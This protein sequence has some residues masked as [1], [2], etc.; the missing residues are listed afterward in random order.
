MSKDA[1][2]EPGEELEDEVEVP[3]ELEEDEES[4]P[5]DAAADAEADY[6]ATRVEEEEPVDTEF[7]AD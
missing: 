4:T 5:L 6:F 3:S 7:S 1:Y 2:D